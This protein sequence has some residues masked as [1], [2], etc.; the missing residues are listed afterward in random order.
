MRQPG[1]FGQLCWDTYTVV[2]FGFKTLP[3]QIPEAITQRLDEAALKLFHAYP[4]LAGQVIKEGRSSTNSGTYKIVPYPPHEGKT[5]VQ[6]KDCTKLCPSYD[7][8]IQAGAPFSM[9]D[10]DILCPMKGMGYVYDETT[11]QPVFMVRANFIQGGLLLCFASMH[12]ALDM[13]GQGVVIRQFAAAVRGEEFASAYLA[14]GN[15]DADSIV[16]LLREGEVALAH[17]DL[18][19]PSSLNQKGP[20][21]K[22]QSGIAPWNYWR[23]PR[24][25]AAELKQLASGGSTWVTTNDAITAFYMQRLTVVRIAAGRVDRD[26]DVHCLRAVNGR[27]KLTPP[28]HEGYLG[29]LVGLA[30]T[31]WTAG[32][33]AEASLSQI[34]SDLRDSVRAVDDH[35]IRSLATL[36]HATDDKTTIFYGAKKKLGKDILISSWA[37]MELANFDW[38]PLL[39]TPDFVRR[40]RLDEVPDLAYMMPRNTHGDIDL[41]ASL[42]A[43]DI[44]GLEDDPIWKSY[45]QLLG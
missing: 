4:F 32:T 31:E 25:K 40:A 21:P 34:A 24:E 30:D 19:K 8:I 27:G 17:A 1:I 45:T 36:I 33:M 20:P 2:V 16:P 6:P 39:G 37:Q 43:D 15:Q 3:G 35:Y 12:N 7:E 11:I 44:D 23:F 13:N 38:G 41:G 29:H 18:R 42:L 26:E 5:P 28:I 9:L 10:G 22:S 14:A